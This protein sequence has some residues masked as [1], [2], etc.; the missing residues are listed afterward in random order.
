MGHSLSGTTFCLFASMTKV[1]ERLPSHKN[2]DIELKIRNLL[3]TTL[4]FSDVFVFRK[5]LKIYPKKSLSGPNL[6]LFASMTVVKL[7]ACPGHKNKDIEL[8]IRILGVATNKFIAV[9]AKLFTEKSLKSLHEL[10]CPS[11]RSP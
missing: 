4:C 8:K 9:L 10:S 11:L 7:K 1:K 2:K 3:Q 6:C 5:S